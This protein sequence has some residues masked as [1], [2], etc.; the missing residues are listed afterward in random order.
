MQLAPHISAAPKSGAASDSFRARHW[1]AL[2][3]LLGVL[4]LAFSALQAFAPALIV[5]AALVL[6]LLGIPHGAVERDPLG[7]LM[8]GR[9]RAPGLMYSGLYLVFGVLVFSSWLIAPWPT[10]LIA[11]ILSAWHF[12]L[13]PGAPRGIG[14]FVVC[15]CFA[16]WPDTT[17]SLF[18]ALT[19]QALSVPTGALVAVGAIGFAAL[20]L[21]PGWRHDWPMRLVLSGVFLVV[22]PVA[23]VAIY[24]FA[25]HSLAESAAMLDQRPDEPAWRSVLRIYGPT[26]LP[27]L[28]GA[29]ALLWLTWQSLVAVP[30]AAGLAVAFIVPHMLPVERLLR[31]ERAVGR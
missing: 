7:A 25:A 16:L 21:S 3:V 10:L 26:S 14:V 11:L 15:A 13:T 17:L 1:R 12:A 19:G 18:G 30:L 28:V 22:H 31:V 5:P 23:A 29:T 27:A 24:F 2:P 4:G 6:F 9:I 8:R 20:W